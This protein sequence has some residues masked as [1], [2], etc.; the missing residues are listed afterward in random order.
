V[1]GTFRSPSYLYLPKDWDKDSVGAVRQDTRRPAKDTDVAGTFRTFDVA[2]CLESI[3]VLAH[4]PRGPEASEHLH[5]SDRR[6]DPFS[7][8]E[9][10][11]AIEKL[12]LLGGEPAWLRLPTQRLPTHGTIIYPDAPM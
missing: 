5:F 2:G 4:A 11:Q 10:N 1:S 8:L 6:W 12:E 9:T 3:Q 7:R